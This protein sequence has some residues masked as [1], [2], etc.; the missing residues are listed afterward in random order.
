VLPLLDGDLYTLLL[1]A[2]EGDLSGRQ[3]RNHS[4][5]ACCVV[6][7]SGGYPGAYKKGKIVQGLSAIEGLSETDGQADLFVFHAGTRRSEKGQILTAGGRVLGVTA[8]G[9][10]IEQAIQRAYLGVD[11]IQ[12]EGA[13]CRRDIGHRAL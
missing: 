1:A 10:S 13:V 2:A 5:A 6:M 9:Q 12:F 4:G 3:V 8:R 11:R 7:A